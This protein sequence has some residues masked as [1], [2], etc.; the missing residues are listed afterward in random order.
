MHF[1]VSSSP[2]GGTALSNQ[3]SPGALMNTKQLI[4]MNRFGV[5]KRMESGTLQANE[6]NIFE[7]A[8]I[9]RSRSTKLLH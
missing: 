4:S 1:T 7:K 5:T 9:K 6:S 3:A 2:E 8:I